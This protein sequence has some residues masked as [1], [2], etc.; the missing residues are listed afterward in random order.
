M[1]ILLKEEKMEQ[2]S[3]VEKIRFGR[4]NGALFEK[5]GVHGKFYTASFSKH[6]KA[7]EEW[8]ESNSYSKNDLE[9]LH[10][11]VS[12]AIEKIEEYEQKTA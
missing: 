4:V 11:A 2:K 8:E 5:E 1:T 9:N 10:M 3:P 6:Y 7:G 12:E